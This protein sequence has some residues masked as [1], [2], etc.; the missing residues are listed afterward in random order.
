MNSTRPEEDSKE[1]PK[2]TGNFTVNLRRLSHDLHNICSACGSQL[3]INTPA[4]A[5]Y[6]HNRNE[7]YVGDCCRHQ[8]NELASHMY[9]W[10][11]SYKRPNKAEGIWRYMDFAKFVALLKDKSLYFSRTDCL[12]DHFEGARGLVERQSEWK[13]HCLEYFRAAYTNLPGGEKSTMSAEEIERNAEKLYEDVARV[14]KKDLERTF[15]SCWHNNDVESEAIWR[16]YCQNSTAGIALQTTVGKLY[17]SLDQSKFI[18]FG[19]VKYVD[20]KKHFSGSY[21]R[22]FWKRK[23]LS[24]EAEIRAVYEIP[25]GEKCD[26]PG[27]NI[28]IDLE[29]AIERVIVSPFSPPWFKEILEETMSRFGVKIP[30]VKSELLEEPFF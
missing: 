6:D 3:P 23:S 20:F 24:H 19:H 18:K 25:H 16:I 14:A 28:S 10:W 22:I 26:L 9:W 4:F 2:S 27:L 29:D 21:D 30:V 13:E 1:L 7:I 12:G 17:S 5:G 11:T 15:V 8:I